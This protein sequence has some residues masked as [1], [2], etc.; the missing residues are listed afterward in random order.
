MKRIILLVNILTLTFFVQA[1]EKMTFQLNRETIEFTISQE[2][3]YVEF[4]ENQKSAVQRISKDG[5]E[6]LSSKSA[7]LKMSELTGTFNKRQQSLRSKISQNFQRI[8]PVLIYNDGTKQ[9]AKGELNI[10][11][12]ANASLD[13]LLI[14]KTFSV[15]PNEFD[16][17]L[18]LVK[19][20][21]ETSEL[22]EL[23]NQLQKDNR[24]EFVEPN[25][26]RMIKPHTND[27]F[28]SSQWAINNQGYLGGT[29]DA[30]M[31][32]DDAW[33]YT[34]GTG[35]KVAVIDEGVDLSHPDLTPNLL[36]GYDAT[37]NGSNGYQQRW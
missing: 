27:P 2:E 33:N 6:E 16:K 32:V 8:E 35:I 12:K 15:Q 3:M 28:F 5:F 22:F 34:T 37:G 20:N 9:I 26:I 19:L 25:F 11:L 29:V 14:G 23:V 17:D 24:I 21:L 31:D 30:D 18:Y 1:Q 10:K 36:N 13:D 4:A 7:I